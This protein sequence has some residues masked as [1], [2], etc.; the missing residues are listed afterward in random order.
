M[1]A[2]PDN[3]S[4][5]KC[6]SSRR[7]SRGTPTFPLEQTKLQSKFQISSHITA[8]ILP[9]S[10][11]GEKLMLRYQKL[12]ELHHIC[13]TNDIKSETPQWLVSFS[14]ENVCRVVV[15]RVIFLCSAT[16]SIP[17]SLSVY[18]RRQFA[19]S[20]H[21]VSMT[22]TEPNETSCFIAAANPSDSD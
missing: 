12:L 9:W 6:L 11:C 8:C 5:M 21:P 2:Q 10:H 14:S 13:V 19:A 15:L 22:T 7:S 4:L 3:H 16:A 1:N 20:Q 18:L 17:S